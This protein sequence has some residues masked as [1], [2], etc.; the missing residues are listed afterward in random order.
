MKYIVALALLVPWA[1]GSIITPEAMQ[2]QMGIGINLGNRIDLYGEGRRLIKEYDLAQFKAAGFQNVRVPVCWDM[3]TNVSTPYNINTTFLDTVEQ[4]VDWS[5]SHNMVTILNTH[6]ELW[7]DDPEKFDAGLPRFEAIW[8]QIA[9][10]F[11]SKNQTLLFEIF[12]EPHKMTATQLNKLNAVVFPI[13]RKT[14]PTRIVLFAGLQYSNPSWLVQNPD[15]LVFPDDTQIMVEFHNYDPWK[16][17]GANPSQTS[18]GSDADRSTL[19]AWMDDIDA[20][21]KAKGHYLYYGEFGV[22][23]AQTPATGRTA[24][25]KAHADEITK[26]GWAASAWND[27][28]GHLIYN[29]DNY[30]FVEDIVTALGKTIPP[31]S[32]APKPDRCC[33]GGS[34]AATAYCPAKSFCTSSKDHCETNCNGLWCPGDAPAPPPPSNRC[35]HG[36]KGCASDAYCPD[37]AFCKASQE[38]CESSCGGKW[39]PS[40]STL[41]ALVV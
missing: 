1:S 35:C 9:E 32:P 29:Y 15:T 31:P 23:N 40:N 26:R 6:H 37:K 25:F 10:R 34:C 20:W 19:S 36:P 39:C 41:G 3:D 24:W 33:H 21:A 14:N 13:I 17:A 4:Y 8:T 16:Y 27:G 22:T 7:L 30:T 28:Q 38:S 11:A 2:K 5:L 18:W 12:N